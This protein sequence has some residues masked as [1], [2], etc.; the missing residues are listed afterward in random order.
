MYPNPPPSTAMT[1]MI[2][3]MAPR[4]LSRLSVWFVTLLLSVILD[5]PAVGATVNR[6][7]AD[8]VLRHTRR[9]SVPSG[10][11]T[12]PS[13]PSTGPSGPRPF[14]WLSWVEAVARVAR[15]Y[16]DTCRP[17]PA[18]RGTCRSV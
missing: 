11:S 13:G 8:R 1:P 14:D 6:S 18:G 5:L 12:G 3:R 4:T 15:R 10:P 9:A 7:D 16:R 17:G 2:A